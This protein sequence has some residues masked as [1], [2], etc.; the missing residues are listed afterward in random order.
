LSRSHWLALLPLPALLRA[1]A[2]KEPAE[3]M[4]DLSHGS[5]I[6]LA[7]PGKCPRCGMT[8]SSKLHR[9]EYPLILTLPP[10]AIEPGSDVLLS[11]RVV[12][13][14]GQPVRNFELVHE[15]L[16]HLFLVSEDLTFFA[17]THPVPREEV[18]SSFP[19]GPPNP[20]M[21]RLLPTT[22]PAGGAPQLAGQ[23]VLPKGSSR[24]AQLVRQ[25]ILSV[26]RI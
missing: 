12:D 22:N 24:A 23:H 9:T 7:A 16:I 25:P 14:H 8:S 11:L 2:I 13:P 15:K 10:N 21:Y 17:H 3:P 1:Q 20:G 4:P 18:P 26:V 19:F 5:G 6:R